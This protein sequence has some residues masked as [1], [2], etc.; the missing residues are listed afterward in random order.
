MSFIIEPEKFATDEGRSNHM[1]VAQK[2]PGCPIND[3]C[4]YLAVGFGSVVKQ[5]EFFQVEGDKAFCSH[6]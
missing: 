2:H 5:C 3:I 1:V 6:E 4:A